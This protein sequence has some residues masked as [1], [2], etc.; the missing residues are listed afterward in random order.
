MD[1]NMEGWPKYNKWKLLKYFGCFKTIVQIYYWNGDYKRVKSGTNTSWATIWNYAV[2]KY[3]GMCISPCVNLSKNIGTD[4]GTHYHSHDVD[5]YEKL[6]IGR[7][8][9]PL[10]YRKNINY[11]R[12]QLRID[13]KEF[14]RIR[15]IGIKN[16]LK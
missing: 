3:D 13:N 6:M 2:V 4:G 7:I 16:K 10:K 9:W 14:F 11:D 5:P 8:K 15:M 1:M 12:E